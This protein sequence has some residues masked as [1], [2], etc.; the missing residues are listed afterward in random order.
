MFRRP[1]P[2]VVEVREQAE[3]ELDIKSLRERQ[4]RKFYRLM[5]QGL[6]G[7]EALSK[8][9]LTDK[10]ENDDKSNKEDDD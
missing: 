10:Q 7:E 2:E 9:D 1:V 4:R 3:F 5:K 6:S 8:L